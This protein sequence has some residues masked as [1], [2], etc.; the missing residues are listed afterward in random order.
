MEQKLRSR[1]RRVVTG[2]VAQ[3]KKHEALGVRSVGDRVDVITRI[4][5]KRKD[6]LGNGR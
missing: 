5:K 3:V 2:N 1:K 6:F 4:I